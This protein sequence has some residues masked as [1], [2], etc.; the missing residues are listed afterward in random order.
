MLD[1]HI[2]QNPSLCEDRMSPCCDEKRCSRVPSIA[3]LFF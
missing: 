1:L 3:L 2:S